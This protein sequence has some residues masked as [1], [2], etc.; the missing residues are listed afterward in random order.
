MSAPELPDDFLN[1]LPAD[2]V[3]GVAVSGGSDSMALLHLL[4]ERGVPVSVATVHHHLRSGA[5]A[6]IAMVADFCATH[7]VPHHTLHW[8]WGGEGNL[9]DQA[10]RGRYSAL[11]AWA[12]ASHITD[13][14]LGHTADDDI[15][16]FL[17]EL[18]RGA[19]LDGLSGMRPSFK[20]EGVTFHRPLLHVRRDMLRDRLMAAGIA[21]CDDPSNEDTNY[22]RVL[23]RQSLTAL[24]AAGLSRDMITKSLEN[25]RSTRRDL[26]IQLSRSLD[27]Q[28]WMEQGDLCFKLDWFDAA[29]AESQRR[30]LKSA[31]QFVSGQDYPPRGAKLA[32]VLADLRQKSVLHGCVI[33]S[34]H[35]VL[36]VGRE[37]AAVASCVTP[38]TACWDSRWMFAGPH[39]N[40]TEIRA[41]GEAGLAQ[42]TGDW[43]SPGLPYAS[44]V[45]SPSVWD[46]AELLSAPLAG[47]DGGWRV[48]LLRDAKDFGEFILSH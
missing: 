10:R 47:W 40:S 43:R 19:G 17:M 23:V 24:E 6:E 14:A 38:S 35:G 16:T 11:S 3:L 46:G 34:G 36:R 5:D 29:T 39:G 22:Q 2:R 4:L 48:T 25:L 32:R 1:E 13:V 30:A 31:L 33:T 45:A 27:G 15:E 37:L 26:D 21:W 44:V 41:L 8:R 28:F 7:G 12:R 18:G 42:C 20:L 9:Q